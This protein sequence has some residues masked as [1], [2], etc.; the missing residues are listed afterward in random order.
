MIEISLNDLELPNGEITEPEIGA[1]RPQ[2][3]SVAEPKQISIASENTAQSRKP[4]AARRIRRADFGE[5]ADLVADERHGI[6]VER[7][8]DDAP[9]LA[10]SSRRSV[11]PKDLDQ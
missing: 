2:C 6:I 1:D 9:D 3:G 5:I 11:V 10:G 7:S 4:A 8:D